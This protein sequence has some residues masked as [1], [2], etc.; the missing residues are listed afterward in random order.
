MNLSQKQLRSQESVSIL[1]TVKPAIPD[2]PALK[3]LL[4][5]SLEDLQAEV[6]AAQRFRQA[7]D[8][9]LA[10]AQMAVQLS[11]QLDALN[12]GEEP[13]PGPQTARI[14]QAVE[15]NV[16]LPITPASNGRPSLRQAI[17][18]VLSAQ[19]NKVW[20][21]REIM[22]TLKEDGWEPRGQKPSAQLATRLAE[23]INRGE[24]ERVKVGHYRLTQHEGLPTA[25]A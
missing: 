6:R 23:M 5:R 20:Q 24:I 9:Y 21:K 18:L 10:W 15:T 8:T 14:G 19:P 16:A 4:D 17:L 13:A 22:A 2:S 1:G 25:P 3:Q 11:M 12:N 7:A